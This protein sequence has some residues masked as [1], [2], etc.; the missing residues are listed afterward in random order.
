LNLKEFKLDNSKESHDT[1]EHLRTEEDRYKAWKSQELSKL[2]PA[3]IFRRLQAQHN[4][5][6][7]KEE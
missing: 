2:L 7:L 5:T 3:D 1:L 4:L 6:E